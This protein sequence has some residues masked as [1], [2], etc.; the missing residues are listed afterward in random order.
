M[1]YISKKYLIS[2]NLKGGEK[3]SVM[4]LVRNKKYKIEIVLGYNGKKKIRHCETFEGKKSNQKY[5]F[6][7]KVNTL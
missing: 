6:V 1:D 2:K 3:M 5:K 7:L 4:E